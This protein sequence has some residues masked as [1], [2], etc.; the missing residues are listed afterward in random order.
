[1]ATCVF[2]SFVKLASKYNT[3]ALFNCKCFSQA[4]K[5]ETMA[6]SVILFSLLVLQ[7]QPISEAECEYKVFLEN[8]I[9]ADR[10]L[11]NHVFLNK[12]VNHPKLCFSKC[13]SNCFCESFNFCGNKCELSSSTK[14]S[15]A[16]DYK[17][18]TNCKYYDMKRVDQ[19]EVII[20]EDTIR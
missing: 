20:N 13:V 5:M 1:M 17:T 8:G 18:E 6:V 15:S 10:R 7:V 14:E 16:A 2:V 3:Q 9:H 11:M 4:F 12:S 19:S